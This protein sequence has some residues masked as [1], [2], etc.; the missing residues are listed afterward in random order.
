MAASIS[1]EWRAWVS[2]GTDKQEQNKTIKKTET[3]NPSLVF[4]QIIQNCTS[5][6][7]RIRTN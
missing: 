7:V 6:V 3:E 4:R 5:E 1:C 2:R